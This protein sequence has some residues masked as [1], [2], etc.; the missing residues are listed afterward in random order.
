MTTKTLFTLIGIIAGTIGLFALVA[1]QILLVEV[2]HAE[3][4]GPAVAMARTV[5][6]LLLCIALI[7]CLMRSVQEQPAVR[8]LLVGDL[9]I[10]LVL[11]PLDVVAY[12]QRAFHTW[13]SFLPNGIMHLV[14]ASALLQ[15]LLKERR[16]A[17]PLTLAP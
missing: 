13:G 2:K 16:R 7:N 15:S 9:A 12:A 14:L 8:A 17:L 4:S 1:P 6:A 5:G 11:M 3:A 10:Q